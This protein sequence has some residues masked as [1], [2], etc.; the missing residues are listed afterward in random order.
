MK[1]LLI[2]SDDYG[3]TD[4]VSC[5]IIK[6]IES[7]IIRNTGIFINMENV[8]DSLYK[9]RQYD[10]CLGIDINY[11]CGKPVSDYTK[12]PHLV[13]M[14]GNFISSQKMIEQHR[15]EK[16]EG[17]VYQFTEDPYPYDEILLET[18]NQVKKFIE[19]TGKKPEYIHAHSLCTP[20]TDRAAK[21]I[22]QKYDI[23]RSALY[24]PHIQALPG[25]IANIKGMS[26]QQQLS[27]DGE[28]AFI[29]E[30]L[31]K[32]QE[33]QDAYY[34]FH[35]GYVDA[36]LFEYSSLTLRRVKDLQVCLSLKVKEYIQNHDIQLITYRDLNNI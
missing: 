27:F 20:N 32:L 3:I 29:E 15:L 8:E 31:S 34:V 36:P 2:Q 18:E 23:M 7:G 9:I 14:N 4:A 28:K 21:E 5:G 17:V 24:L 33:Y 35:A 10:V 11:V 22:A 16:I 19:L 30:S 6:G 1:R 13:D 12:V 25:A 26:L